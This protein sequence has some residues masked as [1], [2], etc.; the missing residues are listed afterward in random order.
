MMNDLCPVVCC[1]FV[2]SSFE[3]LVLDE[4]KINFMRSVDDVVFR[5][6][7]FFSFVFLR[8]ILGFDL[9]FPPFAFLR[10]VFLRASLACEVSSC[11][12]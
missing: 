7:H 6:L 4:R 12:M 10:F 3:L 9:L 2:V 8:V 1:C 5:S 11:I